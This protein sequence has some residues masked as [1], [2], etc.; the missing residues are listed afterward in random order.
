MVGGQLGQQGAGA[1]RLMLTRQ[2]TVVGAM[3]LWATVL[4]RREVGRISGR[5]ACRMQYPIGQRAGT[6]RQRYAYGVKGVWD[7]MQCGRKRVAMYMV[8]KHAAVVLTLTPAAREACLSA[9]SCRTNMQEKGKGRQGPSALSERA[10]ETVKSR[11]LIIRHDME[12]AIHKAV[13]IWH[14]TRDIDCMQQAVKHASKRFDRACLQN[15][16][17]SNPPPAAWPGRPGQPPASWPLL[18]G[19]G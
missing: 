17:M 13:N 6:T 15:S 9:S 5:C 8:S 10:P 14:A 12:L 18:P 16:P 4:I 1:G 2:G 11:Y 7:Y 3:V 19:S